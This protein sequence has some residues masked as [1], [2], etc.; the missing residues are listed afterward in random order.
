MAEPQP[1]R[2]AGFPGL[3]APGEGVRRPYP[4]VLLHGMWGHHETFPT[5]LRFF[6]AAGFDSYAVS[7]RGRRGVPPEQARGVSWQ[8]FL[9]DTR[10][11][12]DE[13]GRE[14]IVLGWSLGGLIAQKLAE[15]GRCRAV[16]LVAPAVPRGVFVLPAPAAI[17]SMIRHLPD[18]ILGRP[19]LPSFRNFVWTALNRIPKD[20]RRQ[21]YQGMVPDSGKV[22]R[23]LSFPAV[24]VDASRVHCPLL[25]IVGSNDNTIP[26]RAVRRVARK[27]GAELR[28]YAQHGHWLTQEPGWET[29]AR[30]VLAWL[31]TNALAPTEGQPVRATTS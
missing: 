19:F 21:A 20:E 10:R 5:Y 31:D 13:I 1:V 29:I 22:I 4:L 9:D 24:A 14:V 16:V 2:I 11:T 23:T 26:P 3:Y 17:P 7:R 18:V 27:Y 15:A 28:E 25:C 6:S 12:L 30:E 8:D